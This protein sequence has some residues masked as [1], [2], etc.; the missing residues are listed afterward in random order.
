MI[1]VNSRCIGIV[2]GFVCKVV[3]FDWDNIVVKNDIG[4]VMNYYML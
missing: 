3:I 4:Y 1:D 2:D